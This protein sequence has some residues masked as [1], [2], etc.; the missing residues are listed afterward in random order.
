MTGRTRSARTVLGLLL[1]VTLAASPGCLPDK[2]T[3]GPEDALPVI[4][5]VSQEALSSLAYVARDDGIFERAGLVVTFTEYSSSQLALEALLAGEADAALCADT[6]IVLAALDGRP[7]TILATVATH[8]NDIQIVAR[9]DAG[10]TAPEDVRGKRIGTREG[11]AAHF[12]L[13]GFLIK[14]GMSDVDVDLRFD[15][16]EGVTAALIAGDLDAVSLRQPFTSQLAVALGDDFVL[17]EEHGLYD[18]T[19]NLCVRADSTTPDQETRRRLVEALLDAERVI[20]ADTSGRTKAEVAAALDLEV[21]ELCN[22]MFSEGAVNLRQSL[23]MALEEQARWARH[24]G[25]VEP[26]DGFDALSLLDTSVLDALA[27]ERVTVI[28]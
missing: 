2:E 7:A 20:S 17:F 15:S 27:P 4:L 19:M 16:F 12:F 3:G 9:A 22:C 1:A 18:K 10:I 6:P 28:R 5:A 11:T 21:D 23:V 14:Y 26:K 13:H 25:I 8:A 24:S